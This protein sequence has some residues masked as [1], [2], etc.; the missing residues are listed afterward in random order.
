MWLKIRILFSALA[1]LLPALFSFS[2]SAADVSAGM[3]VVGNNCS[4]CHA[5]GREGTSPRDGAPRFVDLV[6]RYPPALLAEALA[7]GIMTGHSDM[8][9]FVFT[10]EQI[11]D[12]I[13]YLESLE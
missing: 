8:P 10:P 3:A 7:E 4:R 2:A 6:T 9:E 5:I 11:D 13:L 1:V 12:L